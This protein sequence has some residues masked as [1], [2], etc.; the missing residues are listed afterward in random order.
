MSRVLDYVWRPDGNRRHNWTDD[1][2]NNQN[3]LTEIVYGMYEP[4]T[5]LTKC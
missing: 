3:L 1:E 4:R 2:L 5:P